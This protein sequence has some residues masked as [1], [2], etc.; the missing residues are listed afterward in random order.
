[1]GGGIGGLPANP[2]A[3]GIPKKK[4]RSVP[5]DLDFGKLFTDFIR[6]SKEPL[7]STLSFTS[8]MRHLDALRNHPPSPGDRESLNARGD[9]RIQTDVPSNILTLAGGNKGSRFSGADLK[10]AGEIA[11]KL[12][13][14]FKELDDCFN[15]L[16]AAEKKAVGDAEGGGFVTKRDAY[17]DAYAGLVSLVNSKQSYLK[18]HPCPAVENDPEAE[19]K[20]AAPIP[21][22]LVDLIAFYSTSQEVSS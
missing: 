10:E 18:E 15:K 6:D 20:A 16:S 14:A 2:L 19:M 22:Y 3:G 12:A 5:R 21:Q 13:A 8:Q 1:M 11:G 4:G 17:L 7:F 9:G